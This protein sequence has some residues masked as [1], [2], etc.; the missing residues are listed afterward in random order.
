M[1]CLHAQL[2][3]LPGCT[4]GIRAHPPSKP[5]TVEADS[6]GGAPQVR[7]GSRMRAGPSALCSRSTD[8]PVK[9]PDCDNLDMQTIAV[10]QDLR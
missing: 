10:H 8:A 7:S 6:S 5:F 1:S 2:A 4:G 9:E 3:G